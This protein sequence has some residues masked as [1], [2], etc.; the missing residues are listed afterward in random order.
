VAQAAQ[1]QQ[2][3]QF[4]AYLH[5]CQQHSP[6]P[7][8]QWVCATAGPPGSSPHVFLVVHGHKGLVALSKAAQLVH[9][10]LPHI[11]MPVLLVVQ[12]VSKGTEL[13]AV[14]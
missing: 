9:D 8:K 14:Q 2:E 7:Q 1:H 4:I 11:S 13:Q 5:R 10:C 3:K 6:S 12:L